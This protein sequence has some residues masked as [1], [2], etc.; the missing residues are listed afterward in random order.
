MCM[1]STF[2]VVI[3]SISYRI[4][5]FVSKSQH[6]ALIND[7]STGADPASA[8]TLSCPPSAL[9][10]PPPYFALQKAGKPPP[11]LQ[12]VGKLCPHLPNFIAH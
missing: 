6:A 10:I 4:H 1:K 5:C 11:L 7:T 3:H 8:A 9:P 2:I 12:P